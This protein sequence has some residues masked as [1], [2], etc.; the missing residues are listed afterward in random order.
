MTE[1][2]RALVIE[3]IRR[4]FPKREVVEVLALLDRYGTE[5]YQRETGRVHLAILKL[6]DEKACADPAEYVELACVDYRDVLAMA[7]YPNQIRQSPSID[8][9]LR[10]KLIAKDRAQYLAWLERT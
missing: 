4:V 6:C 8:P 10:E 9:K 1:A 3:K 2:M 5:D 7:E